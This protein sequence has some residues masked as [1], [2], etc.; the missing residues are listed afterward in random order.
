MLNLGIRE[1]QNYLKGDFT[2]TNFTSGP[3]VFGMDIGNMSG[4][5]I[6]TGNWFGGATP[7]SS[8]LKEYDNFF[9]SFTKKNK[10]PVSGEEVNTTANVKGESDSK[11]NWNAEQY[12]K[13]NK[14]YLKTV[15]TESAKLAGYNF[16]LAQ[17]NK[18]PDRMSLGNMLRAEAYKNQGDRSVTSNLGLLNNMSLN[19]PSFRYDIQQFG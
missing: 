16:L 1:L 8:K 14:D 17:L 10:T 2:P 12:K 11:G 3:A 19:L 9:K 6:Q 18:L 5:L 13:I 4:P 15:G 7:E